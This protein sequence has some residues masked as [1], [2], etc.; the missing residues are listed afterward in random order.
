MSNIEELI[1]TFNERKRPTMKATPFSLFFL[2]K[3]KDITR[4]LYQE[5]KGKPNPKD[6]LERI[7]YEWKILSENQ[8]M[9][10]IETAIKLGFQPKELFSNNPEIRGKIEN[11]INTV[12][13]I[14][15]IY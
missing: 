15:N 11:K 10:Y 7:K 3:G 9:I 14:L 8:R 4:N 13:T 12:K 1:K 5:I 2:D 6:L